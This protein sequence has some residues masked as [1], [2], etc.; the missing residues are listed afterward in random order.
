VLRTYVRLVFIGVGLASLLGTP[1]AEA[2]LIV[3]VSQTRTV[4]AFAFD[5][6]PGGNCSTD[7]QSESAPDFGMF[8][9]SVT[10]QVDVNGLLSAS[11]QQLSSLG[12]D[13]VSAVVRSDADPIQFATFGSRQATSRFEFTFDVLQALPFTLYGYGEVRESDPGPVA[14][15]RLALTGGPGNQ[16]IVDVYALDEGGFGLFPNEGVLVPGRYTL[17]AEA[18]FRTDFPGV[19]A[20]A[21]FEFGVVPEPSTGLLLAG[22]LLALAARRRSRLCAR[23]SRRDPHS[24]AST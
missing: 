16:T 3:P 21:D 8:A 2:D 22:G 23:P 5:C 4:S 20:Y 1:S 9:S 12:S 14:F 10:A 19:S 24:A 15:A 6:D 17:I 13:A 18:Q 11:A 7:S